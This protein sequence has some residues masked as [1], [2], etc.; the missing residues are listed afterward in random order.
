M[1]LV[2]A[3]FGIQVLM[4][5]WTL[6]LR[7]IQHLVNEMRVISKLFTKKLTDERTLDRHRD[8]LNNL[9]TKRDTDRLKNR[10]N[11]ITEYDRKTE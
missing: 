7:L 1:N 4:F 9:V 6:L 5:C 8:K 2:L 10:Q 11:F 3:D